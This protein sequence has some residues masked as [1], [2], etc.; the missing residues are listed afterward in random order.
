M[1][2][3][4]SLLIVLL[5]AG[6]TACLRSTEFRCGSDTQCGAGGSCAPV[7]FCAFPDSS[8]T[9]GERYGE[10]AGT[11]ANECVGG[12]QV[13]DAGT[14]APGDGAPA[15][16]PP[17][18]GCPAGYATITGGEGTHRYR[19]AGVPVGDTANWNGQRD[20]CASTSAS[21]YLAIPGD[22]TELAAIATLSA[23]TRFWIGVSDE[24]TEDVWQTVK[25]TPQTF[26]PWANGEPNDGNPGEDCVAAS[27]TELT[28]E[29][30]GNTQLRA[31]CECEP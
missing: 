6:S 17:T 11:F 29:R 27:S 3:V 30:C 2:V 1:Q 20:F 23:S 25:G 22:A 31:V 16:G 24:A 18:T 12:E 5:A 7:G 4:S 9:S 8:C 26:L 14:D 15:D 19:L 10:S 28:D 21:A 13:S